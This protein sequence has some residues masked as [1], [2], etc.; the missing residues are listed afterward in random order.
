MGVVVE[1]GLVHLTDP[2]LAGLVA[3]S[4]AFYARRAA[5]R[6]PSNLEELRAIRANAAAP[7]PSNPPAVVEVVRTGG[8][9]VP[10]RIHLPESGEVTGVFLE[11]HGGG[12]YSGAAAGSDVRNR[13][14]A[15]ALGLAVVSVD[16]RLAPEPPLARRT[17]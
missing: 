8:R 6:G 7:A 15:D 10:V 14:L 11:I 13:N 4:R 2:R 5:G 1:F 3:E 17:R 16:Y 12:F 9:S